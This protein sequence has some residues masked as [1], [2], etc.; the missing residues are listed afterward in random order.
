MCLPWRLD[1]VCLLGEYK[2]PLLGPAFSFR[3]AVLNNFRDIIR[4][5]I[6]DEVS[7]LAFAAFFPHSSV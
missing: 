7:R 1:H 4:C 5:C 2:L 3:S 6:R